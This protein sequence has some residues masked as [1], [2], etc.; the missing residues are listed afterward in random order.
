MNVKIQWE[1]Q[2]ESENGTSEKNK[3]RQENSDHL[4]EPHDR[5]KSNKNS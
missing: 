2:T 1:K 3:T 4:K 5:V